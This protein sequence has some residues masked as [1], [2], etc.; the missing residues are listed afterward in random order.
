MKR[1][2]NGNAERENLR[3]VGRGNYRP[4][5]VR[6]RFMDTLSTMQILDFQK[7]RRLTIFHCTIFEIDT[8]IG[9]IRT[10]RVTSDRYCR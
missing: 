1:K 10:T 9:S 2:G 5:C 3:D 4:T 6:K 7:R 8:A